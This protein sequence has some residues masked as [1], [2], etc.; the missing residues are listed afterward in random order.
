[1]VND[2]GIDSEDLTHL[3]VSANGLQFH[4]VEAGKGDKLALCLH[5]FPELWISWRHQ[6][7][8][9]KDSGWR[10]W[11]PDLRGYGESDAPSDV[12]D[13]SVETLMEDIGALIDASGAKEVMLIA[14]DWGA[15]LAWLFATR[16]VRPLVRLV[17]MNVPHPGVLSAKRPG[18]RQALRSWYIFFFQLPRLPEWALTRNGGAL[19]A[20]AFKGSACHPERF[21]EEILSVYQQAALRPG[22]ARGM[23]N[24]YRALVRGGGARR[25][26]LIGY[27]QIEVPTLFLWGEQ[28]IALTKETT[29]GTDELVADLTLRYLPDASHWVQQDQPE[30]VNE[31]LRCW[32][33][34]EP[35]P[36]ADDSR[37][38]D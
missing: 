3:T 7:P 30:V 31:M 33:E 38:L 17:I 15:I 25:Q 35:V 18:W 37:F 6:I 36:E 20:E 22:R 19:V 29:L 13:Y 24:Y 12:S 11:A 28:D 14:H 23:V 21:P 27:P 34:G 26:A 32:L 9:L 4:V 5:G 1:M 10:V 16:R 2:P 8:F